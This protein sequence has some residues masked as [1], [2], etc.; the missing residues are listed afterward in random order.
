M[1]SHLPGGPGLWYDGLTGAPRKRN[2]GTFRLLKGSSCTSM[3][4]IS[5]RVRS[6]QF[7]TIIESPPIFALAGA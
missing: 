6:H 3:V 5:C 1:Q 2:I 4:V 7:W